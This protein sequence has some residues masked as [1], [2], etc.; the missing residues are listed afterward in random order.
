MEAPD[1]NELDFAAISLGKHVGDHVYLHSSAIPEL[2]DSWQAA[3]GS[4]ACTVGVTPGEQFNVVKIHRLCDEMS[5]LSYPGFFEDPFPSLA[6]SWRLSISRKSFVF[7]TYE[8]SRN[9]PILHRK[10]LLLPPT[11]SRIPQY[12]FIT[13]EAESIGLFEDP[14]RIGFREHWY[15]LVSQRG[16]EFVDGKF[17]PVANAT[18]TDLIQAEEPSADI[19]RHLTALSRTNFSAP[20]QALSRHGLIDTSTTFFDYGC[21]RGDDVR[22]LIA[23]GIDATGWDPHFAAGESKRIADVVN[24]GFVVNVIE[25]ITERVAALRGAYECTRGVLSVAAM[26]S[27]DSRPEGRQYGDGYLSSRNTFQKYFTQA[28]LRD[29]I[30]HTLDE[31]AIAS[32]P[33]VFFVF[34]DKDLEQRF[35]AK[36]YGHRSP[37]IL[38]RGWMR[39]RPH[40]EPR[41]KIDRAL[42]LFEANRTVLEKLWVKYLEL[43]RPPDTIELDSETLS[44]IE[45]SLGSIS[46]A[47]KI[48]IARNDPREVELSR[49]ER[50]SDLLVLFALQ[51]FQKRK[52]YKRRKRPVKA[53]CWEGL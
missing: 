46:K 30:E 24:I 48:A 41:P 36:R 5:L 53:L 28:Q 35:L 33:G 16:Y 43:G 50:N 32:G 42:Q 10:E 51:Q 12:A 8:E 40:R 44:N 31:S 19:R 39:D 6:R 22:G 45:Q 25:N 15:A 11:D 18:D 49:A 26:P 4:A 52:P 34:R 20:V 2:P 17:I 37:T 7:R 3:I 1:L 38:S 23:S 14:N 21:G 9:P 27:S 47:L 13:E 29:F